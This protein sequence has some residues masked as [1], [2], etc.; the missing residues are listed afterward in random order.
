MVEVFMMMNKQVQYLN[1][2]EMCVLMV[3]TQEQRK[4]F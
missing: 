4:A 1:E 3:A 2:I